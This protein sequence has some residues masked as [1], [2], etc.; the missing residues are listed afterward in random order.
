V[1]AFDAAEA[2]IAVASATSPELAFGVA[3]HDALP[4]PA[5]CADLALEGWAFGHALSWNPA[6]WREDVRRWVGELERVTRPGGRLVL[7]ETQGTG[8]ETPFEGGHSLEPFHEFVTRELGF[9][10]ECVR[11]D[12][13]FESVD[14]AVALIG[15]FFGERLVGRVR[16]RSSAIVPE[17]TGVYSRSRG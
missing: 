2:M 15:F 5:A 4:V 12:Y 8:V 14:E 11:T 9:A 3:T 13:A 6:G 7:I 1:R 16:E 10:H 17:C